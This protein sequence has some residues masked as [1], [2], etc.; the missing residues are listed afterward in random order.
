LHTAN[1]GSGFFA[2][3]DIG[4]NEFQGKPLPTIKLS[5]IRIRLVNDLKANYQNCSARIY[6]Y[7]FAKF[8][9]SNPKEA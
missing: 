7:S 9:T 1:K 4:T 2:I 5:I 6:R 8:L 3:A